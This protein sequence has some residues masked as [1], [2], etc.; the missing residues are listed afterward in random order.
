MSLLSDR[1]AYT[2]HTDDDGTTTITLRDPT[3]A[4]GLR[5]KVEVSAHYEV[6]RCKLDP[7]LKAT[8][9]KF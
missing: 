2:G 4:T 7:S 9:F 5:S 1:C 3:G 8:S 6:R